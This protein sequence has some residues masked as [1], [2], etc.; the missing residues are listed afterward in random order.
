MFEDFNWKLATNHCRHAQSL[1]DFL[2]QAVDALADR[3]LVRPRHA[4]DLGGGHTCIGM[5]CTD[6]LVVQVVEVFLSSGHVKPSRIVDKLQ[7][8]YRCI[9]LA[10]LMV[11]PRGWHL[12]EKH[13]LVNG[14]PMSVQT[15][16]KLQLPAGNYE[17]RIVRGGTIVDRQKVEVK[18][19]STTRIVVKR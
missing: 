4:R 18:P 2:R 16:G 7:C 14:K 8:D 11:R 5:Q 3:S 1:F 6:D 9:S 17:I 19:S 10:T 13:A 15:A 12:V